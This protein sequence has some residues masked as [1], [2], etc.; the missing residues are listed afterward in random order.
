MASGANPLLYL[1]GAVGTMILQ[2]R[3]IYPFLRSRIIAASS[4]GGGKG[5]GISLSPRQQT[6]YRFLHGA[7]LALICMFGAVATGSAAT[8]LALQVGVRSELAVS[9]GY[10]VGAVTLA[11]CGAF[12]LHVN[13]QVRQE[14]KE[15][16]RAAA[17][18]RRRA[19]ASLFTKDANSMFDACQKC[20]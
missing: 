13:W 14:Q 9:A 18:A 6:A 11:A 19:A 2:H 1:Y 4:P 12:W 20:E 17:S 8:M 5:R 15:Q 16:K 7:H 10:A 3:V